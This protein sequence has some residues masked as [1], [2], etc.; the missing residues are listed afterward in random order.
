[1]HRF[2]RVCGRR[3]QSNVYRFVNEATQYF[4]QKIGKST[5]PRAP[6]GHGAS[7]RGSVLSS[8]L[9]TR[10][11]CGVDEARLFVSCAMSRAAD[12]DRTGSVH[13]PCF[14]PACL[15]RHR[16]GFCKSTGCVQAD[17]IG[18]N[19]KPCTLL[20]LL[21][22]EAFKPSHRQWLPNPVHSLSQHLL[23]SCF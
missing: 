17:A 13:G 10:S 12:V 5:L 18:G 15:L 11:V 19:V 23:N 20:G 2:G 1:M 22:E 14:F 16:S 9:I 3:S 4:P 6:G 21:V 7:A 8:L